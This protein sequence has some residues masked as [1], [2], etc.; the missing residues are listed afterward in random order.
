M[1]LWQNILAYGNDPDNEDRKE[2]EELENG[3]YGVYMV[4]SSGQR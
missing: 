1:G 3:I 2:I 4:T